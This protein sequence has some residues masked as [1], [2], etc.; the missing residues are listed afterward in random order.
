MDDFDTALQ[1]FFQM[2]DSDGDGVPDMIAAV[3]ASMPP[4]GSDAGDALAAGALGAIDVFGIPSAIA[5][6]VFGED[7]K[8]AMRGPQERNPNA[9]LT[10]AMLSPINAMA[11]GGAAAFGAV[12]GANLAGRGMRAVD[13][14]NGALRSGRPGMAAPHLDEAEEI[15]NTAAPLIRNMGTNAA[16]GGAMGGAAAA[17]EDALS[18]GTIDRNTPMNAM[19]GAAAGGVSGA[20]GTVA[21]H[22][23]RRGAD[24]TDEI[25]AMR[26]RV[27]LA[28]DLELAGTPRPYASGRPIS[29]PQG[30]ALPP[31]SPGGREESADFYANLYRDQ[32]V[33]YS[34]DGP[35]AFPDH[36]R[37][38]REAEGATGRYRGP[39]GRFVSDETGMTAKNLGFPKRPGRSSRE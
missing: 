18:R 31:R 19:A 37:G 6:R 11:A 16:A 35:R 27:P 10:G 2:L 4:D 5:G 14:A 22:V 15:F 33:A 1:G 32:A 26:S 20:L 25:N 13:A 23:A 24:P 34:P 38:I 36:V 7:A 29:S 39:R 9:A 12:R 21:G 3:P 30:E 17:T 28:S 8:N